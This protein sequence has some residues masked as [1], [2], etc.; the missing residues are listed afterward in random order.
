MNTIAIEVAPTVSIAA[1]AQAV[2]QM[3]HELASKNG[4]LVVRPGRP[5]MVG[6]GNRRRAGR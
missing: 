6:G 1:L 3:G 4:R 5:R 2:R